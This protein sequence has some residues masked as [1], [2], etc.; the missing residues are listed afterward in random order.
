MSHQTITQATRDPELADRIT[1]A[2]AKE[3]WGN[4]SFGATDTGQSVRVNGPEGA[5]HYFTWP[6]AIDYEDE[7]AYAVD[8]GNP[9]PGGDPGV[10]TDEMLSSAV[11]AH[12]P[13]PPPPPPPEP[14]E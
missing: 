7:Y 8:A 1:A 3:S 10:I 12:W 4:E 6:V 11:Q 2:V 9:S 14:E 5:T 13:D